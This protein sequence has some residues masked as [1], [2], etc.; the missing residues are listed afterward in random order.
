MLLLY[1][2]IGSLI[3]KDSLKS[4]T[5]QLEFA[6]HPLW[7]K[8]S[9]VSLN[10]ANLG[11]MALHLGLP[12]HPTH[13]RDWLLPNSIIRQ[14]FGHSIPKTC[15][16]NNEL[17]CSLYNFQELSCQIKIISFLLASTIIFFVC[18]CTCPY[19]HMAIHL[20][21]HKH[22]THHH[23][24]PHDSTCQQSFGHSIPKTCEL[25]N[26]LPCTFYNFKD[27]YCQMN[28]ETSLSRMLL[29][30]SLFGCL[31]LVNACRPFTFIARF[32]IMTRHHYQK[33]MV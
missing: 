3:Q 26:E 19:P 18:A 30:L 10:I 22:P 23:W 14:S 21:I 6:T 24:L 11:Y 13:P 8:S 33:G 31:T 16:T 9:M 29:F 17:C 4:P 28:I 27:I 12:R 25:D 32:H 1:F 5:R 2:L 20:G 15:E 7:F